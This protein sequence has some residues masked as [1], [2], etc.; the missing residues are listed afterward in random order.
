MLFCRLLPPRAS[1]SSKC[2]LHAYRRHCKSPRVPQPSVRPRQLCAGH[3]GKNVC[4]PGCTLRARVA[5]VCFQHGANKKMCAWAG[6]PKPAHARTYGVCRR[7]RREHKKTTASPPPPPG[8]PP[9]LFRWPSIPSNT[10]GGAVTRM[11]SV[12]SVGAATALTFSMCF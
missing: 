8:P 10:T 7:L 4:R 9:T 5:N 3:G 2:A 1:P 6:C 12:V 11:L